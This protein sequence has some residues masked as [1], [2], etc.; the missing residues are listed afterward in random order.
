MRDAK[1]VCALYRLL[2]LGPQRR[3]RREYLHGG[4]AAA[5]TAVGSAQ[6]ALSDMPPA[7]VCLLSGSTG[8]RCDMH[9]RRIGYTKPPSASEV[10][11]HYIAL[12]YTGVPVRYDRVAQG[13][14]RRLG[15]SCLIQR[16][17]EVVR[18]LRAP[19]R[20]VRWH[21]VHRAQ[22]CDTIESPYRHSQYP[23]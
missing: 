13:R 4:T 22:A 9:S 15:P 18:D 3:K 7:K 10:G 16:T 2:D 5:L 20:P 8:S 1:G 12:Q 6:R 23:E 14:M 11:R 17:D 19:A 21:P